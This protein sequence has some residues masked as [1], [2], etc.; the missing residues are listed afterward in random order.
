MQQ[1]KMEEELR[2]LVAESATSRYQIARD[3]GIAYQLILRFTNGQ[4]G[5]QPATIEKIADAIGYDLQFV[6][7]GPS[8]RKPRRENT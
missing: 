2:R 1:S 7:R 5:L 6:K 8:S 3:A 4:R